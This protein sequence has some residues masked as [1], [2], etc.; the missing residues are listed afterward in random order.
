MGLF[1]HNDPKYSGLSP[2]DRQILEHAHGNLNAEDKQ[3]VKDSY[4]QQNNPDH[5]ANPQHKDHGAFKQKMGGVT[6]KLGNAA[7]F[8]FGATAGADL[9]NSIF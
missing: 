1:H 3:V 8:G 4:N 2:E 6:S 9:F 5:P 7:V